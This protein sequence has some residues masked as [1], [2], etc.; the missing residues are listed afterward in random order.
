MADKITFSLP[1]MSARYNAYYNVKHRVDN[2]PEAG[3]DS[4][5]GRGGRWSTGGWGGAGK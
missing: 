3:M 5:G 2:T 1:G 4:V